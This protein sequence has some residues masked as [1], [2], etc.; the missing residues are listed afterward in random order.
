MV[1]FERGKYRSVRG[2]FAALWSVIR[3]RPTIYGCRV[4]TND[5]GLRATDLAIADTE[6][7]NE[8]DA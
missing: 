4:I 5:L 6:F 3:A 8:K 7:V 1:I 2:K